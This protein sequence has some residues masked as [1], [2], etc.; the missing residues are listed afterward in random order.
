MTLVNIWKGSSTMNGR[1]VMFFTIAVV[2]AV[3]SGTLIAH[4]QFNET[5]AP[6]RLWHR[7]LGRFYFPLPMHMQRG[8]LQFLPSSLANMCID[9]VARF[10]GLLTYVKAKLGLTPSQLG[11]RQ[12]GEMEFNDSEKKHRET[13]AHLSAKFEPPS[14]PQTLKIAEE[15]HAVRQRQLQKVMPAAR[16]LYEALSTDQ[17]KT[18]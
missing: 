12:R 5:L 1:R 7:A 11:V 9:A 4:A 17:R 15:Q 13:C 18:F 2:T 16:K 14:S 6:F 8:M 3:V 10:V